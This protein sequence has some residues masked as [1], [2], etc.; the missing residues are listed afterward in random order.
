MGLLGKTIGAC[1]AGGIA[2]KILDNTRK[3]YKKKKRRKK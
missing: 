3:K 1:L 2:I